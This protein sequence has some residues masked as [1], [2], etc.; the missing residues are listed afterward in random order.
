MAGALAARE[1][2]GAEANEAEQT[3]VVAG[4]SV[5]R[6]VRH[7]LPDHAAELVSVTAET[8]GN[9]YRGRVRQGVDDEVGV[10][11]RDAIEMEERRVEFAADE[12]PA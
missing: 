11:V 8:G 4:R 1:Q 9:A 10:V 12:E 2:S 6:E 3:D 5:H 7:D